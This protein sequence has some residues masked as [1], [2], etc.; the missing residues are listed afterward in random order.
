MQVHEP[1]DL[2]TQRL[3]EAAHRQAVRAG[4]WDGPFYQIFGRDQIVE[5][6]P[7]AK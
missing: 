7:S 1:F 6:Q 5:F 3:R 4:P 2:E